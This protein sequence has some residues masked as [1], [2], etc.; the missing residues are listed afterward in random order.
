MPAVHPQTVSNLCSQLSGRREHQRANRARF[1]DLGCGE[2]MKNGER[3]RSS[4][5]CPCLGDT[6][7]VLTVEQ[8][9]NGFGL[10]GCRFSVALGVQRVKNALVKVKF[11]EGCHV[12]ASRTN[13]PGPMPSDQPF[14]SAV[15]PIP[16]EDRGSAWASFPRI[17]KFAG[18]PNAFTNGG[19]PSV[20]RSEREFV[21]LRSGSKAFNGAVFLN[22]E[23]FKIPTDVAC[24]AAS[25]G[26]L[27]EVLKQRCTC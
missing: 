27:A 9:G 18:E 15:Q 2:M 25:D 23:F 3:K 24:L 16:Y 22:D 20:S 6:E 1:A 13:T 8:G 26:R 7:H 19:H 17:Q 11:S 14:Q 4:L 12:V 5:S 21:G 10:N